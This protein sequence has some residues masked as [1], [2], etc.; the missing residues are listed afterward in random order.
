MKIKSGFLLRK[1]AGRN[2][3]AASGDISQDFQG[4]ITLNETGAFL[5]EKLSQDLT[6]EELIKMLVQEYEVGEA[7]AVKDVREFL[8]LLLQ[9]HFLE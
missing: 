5:W 4:I 3:V 2:I 6:E 7:V 8:D 1:V 9:N